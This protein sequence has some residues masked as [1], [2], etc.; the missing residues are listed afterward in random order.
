MESLQL[1]PIELKGRGSRYGEEFYTNFKD[2]VND[3]Y[4]N[5][6]NKIIDDEHA[7]WVHSIGSLLAF[8]LYY[9]MVENGGRIPKHV[10]VFFRI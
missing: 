5:I 7:I 4:Q 3:I 10:F 1:E 6:K 8:E 9:K 2:V